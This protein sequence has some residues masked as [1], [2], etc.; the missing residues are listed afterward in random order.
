MIQRLG[1]AYIIGVMLLT[2]ALSPSAFAQVAAGTISGTVNDP[3]GAVVPRAQITILNEATGLARALVTN[4]SGFFSAPNLLPG[5]YQI[6]TSAKGFTTVVEKLELKVGAEAV[7]NVQL[8]VGGV[9]E[10]IVIEG[11][12]PAIDQASS[13]LSAAVEGQTVRDLPLNGRNWT[14]LATLEPGVHTVDTQNPFVLGNAGRANRGLGTQL[15]VGGA[16][17]QQNNYRLDGVSINDYSG[18]GPGNTLG[19]LLGVE[20]IQEFSVVTGNASADYGKTSG[21]VFNAITRS[22]TNEFHGSAYEFLRNSSLDARNFFDGS[23]VPPFKRNQ[24]GVSAGGPIRKDRTFLFGDYEGLR[25]ALSTTNLLT[26]PSRAARTGQLTS[27]RV[28]V[29]QKV[30]PYLSLYPSPNV[31][32]TG[33]VGFASLVQNNI[34]DENFFTIRLDHKFSNADSMHGTFFSDNGQ[35]AGPDTFNVLRQA[36]ISRRKLV[37]LEE[38]HVFGPS[39]YNSV[40]LGYSR[41]VAF[42]PKTLEVVDSKASD[43]AL[44]FLPG[45]LVGTI[46]VS[47]LSLFP[48]VRAQESSFYY[49]SYQVYDDLFHTRGAHALKLGF[50]IERIQAN[51]FSI[52]T[53]NGQFNFGSLRNFLTNQ[54][55]SFTAAVPGFV[56]NPTYLRQTVAGGYVQDD[57]RR[58]PNLT[59]NLGL[60]YELATVP[61]EKY[62]RLATLANLTDATPK[63]GSPYFENP[64]KRNFSPRFGFAWDPFGDGKTSIRAGFGVYDTLPL[65]YQFELLT[66]LTSPFSRI[67]VVTNPPRGSF[68]TDVIRLITPDKDRVSFVEQEPKRSYVLQWNLNLERE[69]S[70]NLI[71]QLGYLGSHGVHQPFRTNDADI[72]LPI[73]TPQG[74]LWPTPRGSGNRLNENVGQIQALAWQASTSYHALNLK[75]TE[76]L[77]RG[78]QVG[79][80]YTWGKSID[81]SSASVIGGQFGNSVNGLPLSFQRLWRGRSDFDVRHTFVLNYLWLIPGPHSDNGL[82]RSLTNGWQWGGIFRASSGLPF[83]PLLGGDALGMKSNNPFDFPDRVS[84][85]GCRNPVN[86]GDPDHY[87]KVECFLAPQPSNRLG[88]GGRNVI[89]G[90]GVI[91]YDL[92]LH[93][94]NY[95]RRISETFNVQFRAEFFNVLNRSN[96]RPP[97]GAAAQVFT[98]NLTPNAGAGRLTATATTSRQVQLALKVNW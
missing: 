92:S 63:L 69:L 48:G 34:T 31:S 54:P 53:P 28:T 37:T 12:A 44:A 6:T 67:G 3:S 56:V 11:D 38:S 50:A 82:I 55:Q 20:A 45:G 73:E 83:T 39:L 91:D 58:R 79:G 95:V 18:G 1:F 85:S 59:M 87:I 75:A 89:T 14:Q 65:T 41:V 26:V 93:K 7:A 49:N 15:T 57:W 46:G 51:Q 8:K 10:E 78:L 84:T 86:S 4:D 23:Q 32:E 5:P 81:N 62:N 43:P 90:P 60:R 30:V 74:L 64:T 35:T 24:F 29:D 52:S 19:A 76:R 47:G 33:D 94:N 80:S 16:R 96:F 9:G 71:L 98:V 22:G 77:R 21:G 13:T 61:A 68:P 88:N 2:L 17:P 72:V 70:Q 66:L 36:N 25:E 27:G 42:S 40:R 97:S